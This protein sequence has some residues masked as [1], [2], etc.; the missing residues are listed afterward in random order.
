MPAKVSV[1]IP[2]KNAGKIFDS[3]LTAIFSNGADFELDV[4]VVDS[5]SNDG[6]RD[7]AA[8]YPVKL[9]EIPPDS[10]SHGGARNLG[11]ENANGQFLVFLTQDAMPSGRD[12]LSNLLSNFTDN[13]VAGVYGRQLPG[14]LSS[15]VEKFFLEYLYP[16]TK[17]IK[18]SVDPNNCL[19]REIFF[20]NVNSAIKRSE[21]EANRFNEDL[22][23][24]E[25][26]EWAKRILMKRKKLVY[27]PS[28][29]VIH[30]HRYTFSGLI[31]RNF[32]SGMSL[33]GVVNAPITRSLGYELG[34]LR[35]GIQ[36]FARTG[37]PLHIFIFLFY[38]MVRMFGF[39]LGFYSRILPLTIKTRISPN[40]A[41]WR[42][43]C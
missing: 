42:G 33:R 26:Q 40:K 15:P 28:A 36:Y 3:V 2:T 11:A 41:Y 27:E 13:D 8:K 16:D 17:S 14:G 19:L 23:M 5:G 25:D 31:G 29:A 30:N 37:K 22:I 4:I 32:D 39:T 34:Y 9:V 43:R 10:F 18:N 6:T 12:W 20:S 24:S 35:D 1:I 38:E 21:W 7:V